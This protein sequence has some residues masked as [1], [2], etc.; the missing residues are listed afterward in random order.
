[1]G[2][3]EYVLYKDE[4]AS[5]KDRTLDLM[6]R[7]TL[8]EKVGQLNQK[9]Y[10][11]NIYEYDPD[12]SLTD[13]FK[14]EVEK[15]GGLGCLYGLHRADPW[16]ARTM[17]NGI[18]PKRSMEAYNAVQ[19]Y[20]IEHS[21]LGIPVLM[22][23]ENPHGHQAL[24]G[25]ILPVNTA[26]G[27]TFDEQLL[28]DSYEASGKQLRDGHVDLAL[29][30]MLDVM[31]DPRWG[32][33]E[34]CYSE[35]PVLCGRMAGAAVRGV[36]KGG[37]Y[38][39][40]KHFCAQG[41]TTG[42]VNASAAR[43][44]ERELR[45]IH[46]EPARCAVK[47]GARGVMAA[48]NE[49]DGVYC[50][51]NS[52]LLKDIL[53]GEMGFDGVVMADGVAIDCLD[54]V[55]YDNTE[56]GAL[57]LKSGVNISLW[58]TGFSKLEDAVKEGLI[59]EEEIDEALY[60]VLYM[61]FER[62]LFEHPY[63]DKN[64]GDEKE[65]GIDK[66]SLQMA[67]ESVVLLKNENKVL[68]VVDNKKI[69]VIGENAFDGY[70]LMGDYTPPRDSEDMVTVL[71]GLIEEF[72]KE[73]VEYIAFSDDCGMDVAKKIIYGFDMA[74]FVTGGSSSRY[75][76]AKFDINGASL[77]KGGA[78]ECGE[79]MDRCNIDIFEKEAAFI[80]EY[81]KGKLPIVALCIAGRPYAVENIDE[82]SDAFLYSFYPGPFGGKAI[83]EIIKGKMSP[84][85]RLPASL[86]KTAGQVPVYYNYK[87]SYKAVTYCDIEGKA[88]YPFGYGLMYSDIEYTNAELKSEALDDKEPS[89]K[90]LKQKAADMLKKAL[91]D[92]DNKEE[93][94]DTVIARVSLKVK[95]KGDMQACAIPQLYI[96]RM[97]GG[98]TAR[99]LELKDFSRTELGVGEEKAMALELKLRDLIFYDYNMKPSVN[100]KGYEI[101]V[102][103]QDIELIRRN[104][105][106]TQE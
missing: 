23:S 43:I 59:S 20:V 36:Q 15:W 24:L 86:P 77:S 21:R 26:A 46:L 55:T 1:M 28:E 5:L 78:M 35:D 106:W 63:M 61:K 101:V 19:K 31:R 94:L 95:N 44:G 81:L 93:I 42:G 98:V 7:M 18:T 14:N 70:A 91:A 27:A 99:N 57:A 92:T 62:G 30:S 90:N 25:G 33:C 75:A 56:S 84:M 88:A 49:I 17:E 48:Y 66:Y 38:S 52:H 10:G 47:E 64:M 102:K 39:V 40:A 87:D 22:S 32:R 45:E 54:S 103:D 13:E 72:G 6:S 69:A 85:G 16:S 82:A 11:F 9:L 104:L 89:Y 73:N 74:L 41:E 29:M 51:A 4:K 3:K 80:R 100:A 68:P 97:G 105:E 76:G 58:D 50:H 79:G 65:Y 12:F 8:T 83:A 96:H 71:D 67:R 2:G 60:P 34:E 53:R 37:T